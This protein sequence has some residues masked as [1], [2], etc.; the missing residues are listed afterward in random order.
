MGSLESSAF[1]SQ[2]EAMNIAHYTVFTM[3]IIFLRNDIFLMVR[4]YI[5]CVLFNEPRRE[6][7][8]Q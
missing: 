8:D 4:S 6:M 3:Q 5:G 7:I 2:V 1:F